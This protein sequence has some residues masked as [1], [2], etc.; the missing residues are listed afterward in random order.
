MS[1]A[2]DKQ[3]LPDGVT[4]AAESEMQKGP[5]GVSSPSEPIME[6]EDV[7]DD[8]PLALFTVL[9][10]RDANTR[11]PTQV[12]GYEVPVILEIYGE[13]RVFVVDKEATDTSDFDVGRAY[14]GLQTKYRAFADQL[15]SIYGS[16][17]QFARI[18]GVKAPASTAGSRDKKS[19]SKVRKL[20]VR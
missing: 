18:V 4:E 2:T 13:D 7:A 19:S 14:D 15:R 8:D 12:L 5:G 1:K 3:K 17:G 11:I 10:D 20:P 9:I 16:M 6:A